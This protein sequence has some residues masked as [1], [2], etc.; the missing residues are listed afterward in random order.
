MLEFISDCFKTEE[1]YEK[2]I[3]RWLYALALAPDHYK[4]KQMFKA[5]V[6]SDSKKLRFVLN[7]YKT[8]ITCVI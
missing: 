6:L 4:T 8:H 7:H 2:A 3:E 1:I 5:A